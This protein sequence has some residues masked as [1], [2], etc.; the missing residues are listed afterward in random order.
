[1]HRV[2]KSFIIFLL[3]IFIS[4]C[5]RQE[6]ETIQTIEERP[7]WLSGPNKEELEPGVFYIREESGESSFQNRKLDPRDIAINQVLPVAKEIRENIL[8]KNFRG[9]VAKTDSTILNL[10]GQANGNLNPDQHEEKIVN[11]WVDKY[12]KNDNK[13]PFCDFDVIMNADIKKMQ[14][15]AYLAKEPYIGKHSIQYYAEYTVAF[16]DSINN[17]LTLQVYITFDSKYK[18]PGT[19]FYLIESFWDHCPDPN[20]YNLPKSKNDEF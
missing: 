16:I 19:E 18:R 3:V 14:I 20:L 8:K 12:N 11:L 13:D 17:E 2:S 10:I 1:M 4:Q 9:L 5:K 7:V 6:S 15:K